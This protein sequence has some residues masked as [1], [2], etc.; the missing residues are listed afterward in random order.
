MTAT[1]VELLAC[2]HLDDDPEVW[3]HADELD[4]APVCSACCST[5]NRSDH[6][7]TTR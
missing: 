5:C 1:T 6:E 4:H 2:G 7:E 3:H